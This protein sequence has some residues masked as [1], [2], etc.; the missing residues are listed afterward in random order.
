VRYFVFVV[1]R[2]I[3]LHLQGFLF[4]CLATQTWPIF[5]LPRRRPVNQYT[6][7][8]LLAR[9]WVGEHTVHIRAASRVSLSV[10]RQR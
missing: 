10:S 2:A 3:P 1:R 4:N 7:H 6:T 5:Q 9:S 8:L